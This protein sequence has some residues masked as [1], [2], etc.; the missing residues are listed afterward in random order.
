MQESEVK[1]FYERVLDTLVFNLPK[2]NN[3]ELKLMLLINHL[4]VG[5]NLNS[6]PLSIDDLGFITGLSRKTL[7]IG[8]K[9]LRSLS[10]IE[11]NENEKPFR[12]SI[13][14]LEILKIS[15]IQSEEEK[16]CKSVIN[17]R[18]VVEE[19]N[20][21]RIGITPGEGNLFQLWNKYMSIYLN[22]A[23]ELHKKC[24]QTFMNSV[25]GEKA[26]KALQGYINNENIDLSYTEEDLKEL[27][28][29]HE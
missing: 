15:L 6:V 9:R 24:V 25:S 26:L 12:Y 27:F 2:L 19:V 4:T 29:V 13:N 1:T 21:R 22:P 3:S 20:R 8:L 17:S 18:V 28:G 7:V 5:K 23:N 14:R 16:A 10:L 11:V